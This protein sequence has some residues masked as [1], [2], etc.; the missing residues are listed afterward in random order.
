MHTQR[1]S[2][3]PSGAPRPKTSPEPERR[4][5]VEP[6]VRP[7]LLFLGLGLLA[8]APAQHTKKAPRGTKG[9]D[10][11]SRDATNFLARVVPTEMTAVRVVERA[12]SFIHASH[13]D[14][15]ARP[16][17]SERRVA[18]RCARIPSRP[19]REPRPRSPARPRERENA[20][21]RTTFRIRD[22]AA[23][24][25]ATTSRRRSRRQQSRRRETR[26]L[27]RDD[28]GSAYVR[29]AADHRSTCVGVH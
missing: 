3:E 21:T 16:F 2:E 4:H 5:G 15:D 23:S 13:A 24:P 18:F 6:R 10:G 20:R 1:C 9:G 11:H 8:C 12:K 28:L 26:P 27:R 22:R 17:A 14:T 29:R 19:S 25:F 7:L